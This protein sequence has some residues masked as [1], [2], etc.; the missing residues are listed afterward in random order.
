MVDLAATLGEEPL[1]QPSNWEL[2]PVSVKIS[3]ALAKQRADL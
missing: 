2:R 3:E 1:A